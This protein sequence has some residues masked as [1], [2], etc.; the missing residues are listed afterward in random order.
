MTL[1][2]SNDDIFIRRGD[3]GNIIISGLP[4]DKNYGVYFSI[5]NDNEK[6][7]KEWTVNSYNNPQVTFSLS[8]SDT[9]DISEGDYN[10]GIKICSGDMEDTLIPRTKVDNGKIKHYTPL[11]TVGAKFVEGVQ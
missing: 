10:Y 2:L 5:V 1:F 4:T 7:I 3:S 8:A 6:I 11:F 9:D